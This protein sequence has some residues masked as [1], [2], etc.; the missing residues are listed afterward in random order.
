MKL[1]VIEN[2]DRLKKSMEMTVN[3]DNGVHS[4]M[5]PIKIKGRNV[6]DEIAEPNQ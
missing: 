3:H 6:L 5:T 2:N 1:C 4:V